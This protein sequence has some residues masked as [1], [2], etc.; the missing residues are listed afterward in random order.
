M[1][2]IVVIIGDS[3]LTQGIFSYLFAHYT[4]VYAL[5]ASSANIFD[6]V[7]SIQP[8]VVILE[9]ECLWKDPRFSFANLCKQFS[10]L[11][12]LELRADTSEVN[13]IQTELRN[14]ANLEEM[15]SFL[16]IKETGRSNSLLQ[17]V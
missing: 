11:M 2:K 5:D 3:L 10:H 1:K 14:P 4:Q 13:V 9:A 12:V 16:D 15:V 8:D 17:A 6:Q 7:E